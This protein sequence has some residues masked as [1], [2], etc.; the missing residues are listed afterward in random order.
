MGLIYLNLEVNQKELA[1]VLGLTDRR[2]R[3]LINDY[4]LFQHHTSANAKKKYDLSK[5]VQEYIN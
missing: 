2:I 5:C 4:G 3:H 1:A